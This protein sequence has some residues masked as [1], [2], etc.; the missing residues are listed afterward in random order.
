MD[1]LHTDSEE[2][3]PIRPSVKAL[4]QR[5]VVME[6]DDGAFMFL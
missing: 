4:S 1:Y 5:R 2:E 3:F 6:V